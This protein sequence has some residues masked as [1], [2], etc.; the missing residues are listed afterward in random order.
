MT[1]GKVP[2]RVLIVDDSSLIRQMLS[3]LLS[4]DPDIEVPRFGYQVPHNMEANPSPAA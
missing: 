1:T 3:M 2:V 4:A